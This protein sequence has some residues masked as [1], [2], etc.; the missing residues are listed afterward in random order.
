M[1]QNFVKT[2]KLIFD[3]W[4]TAVLLGLFLKI[5]TPPFF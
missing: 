3:I 1:D 4:G 5:W 2:P